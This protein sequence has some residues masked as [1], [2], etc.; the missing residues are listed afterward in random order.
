ML[1]GSVPWDFLDQWLQQSF[2]F[3]INTCSLL[4]A[5]CSHGQPKSALTPGWTLQP[6]LRLGTFDLKKQSIGFWSSVRHGEV[7]RMQEWHPTAYLEG[8]R[9]RCPASHTCSLPPLPAEGHARGQRAQSAG[10]FLSLAWL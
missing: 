10:G 5:C 2:S 4:Q 9:P 8:C 7:L 3:R 6:P 1:C